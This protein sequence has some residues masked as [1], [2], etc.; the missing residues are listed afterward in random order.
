V[1]VDLV[2]N[3]IFSLGERDADDRGNFIAIVYVR[4]CSKIEK[5]T[6]R[7]LVFKTTHAACYLLLL[8]IFYRLLVGFISIIYLNLLLL[9]LYLIYLSFPDIQA[10]ESLRK[11]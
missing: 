3:G 1:A 6:P 2:W 4:L 9:S 11:T 7:A 5:N 8:E 10:M